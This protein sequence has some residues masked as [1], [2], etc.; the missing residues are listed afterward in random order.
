MAAFYAFWARH[1]LFAAT[2]SKTGPCRIPSCSTTVDQEPGTPPTLDAAAVGAL[3]LR[4]E[5]DG[6]TAIELLVEAGWL[7]P[8]PLLGRER[9]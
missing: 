5:P 1:V 2:R 9:C 3:R 6:R 4:N 8:G 7:H